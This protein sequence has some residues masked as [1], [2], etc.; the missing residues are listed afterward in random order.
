MAVYDTEENGRT[1][2][3]V[4]TIQSLLETVDLSKHRLIISD[5]GS[6]ES[7]RRLYE[8][9]G[10]NWKEIYGD[11]VI[12]IIYNGENL[13]TA[14]AINRAWAFRR[15]GEHAIKMDNDVVIH[16]AGWVDRLE[17][18]IARDSH[19]GICGLKRKDCWENPDHENEFY[20][21]KIYHLPHQPGE[22]WI[23]AEEVNHVMGTCQM[24]SSALLDKIGYLFQPGIYGFDDVFAA[25]RCRLAG[26]KSVFIPY[27]QIDH[28]D[29]GDSPY[30]QWKEEH[31]A[32]YWGEYAKIKM[33]YETG[34]RSIYYNPFK[35]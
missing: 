18:A 17:E 30:Q 20:R 24:Y 7:T 14:E 21:S 31:A 22:S 16:Q 19:I 26:F 3:T 2:Y 4:K 35:K 28:I 10:K 34:K 13:G 8:G 5:N 33:E 25:I 29:R 6:C 32:E 11:G 12:T 15:P 23:I 27:I 9:L 1:E